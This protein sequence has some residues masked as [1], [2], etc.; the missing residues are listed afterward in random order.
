M[1][2]TVECPECEASIDSTDGLETG[3]EVAEVEPEEDGSFQLYENHDLFFCKNCRKPLGVS[4]P[5]E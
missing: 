3:G 4:R 2:D 1:S 5:A